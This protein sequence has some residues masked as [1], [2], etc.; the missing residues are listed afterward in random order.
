MNVKLTFYGWPDNDP[1]GNAIAYPGL[2]SSSHQGAGGTGTYDDPITVAV[3]TQSNNGLWSPGTKMYLPSLKKYLIV[4]DECASCAQAQIDVWMN[5]DGNHNDEVLACQDSLT[6]AE[7]VE[8]EI[9]P[10]TGRPVR[11]EPL[12]DIARGRCSGT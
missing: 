3:V 7:D 9:D 5:S 6:P 2:G 8:V 4:E 11:T 1:P 12:F 10:P